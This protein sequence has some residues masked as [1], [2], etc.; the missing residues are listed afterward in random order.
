[1][2]KLKYKESDHSQFLPDGLQDVEP[3]D[4]ETSFTDNFNGADSDTPGV[5]LTWTELS[6]DWDV[7]SNEHVIGGGSGV[8]PP[9]MAR[10][11]SDVSSDDHYVQGV[12]V[13][14][15]DENTCSGDILVRAAPAGTYTGYYVTFNNPGSNVS[16][17][18]VT[19]GSTTGL[20]GTGSL[21][22]SDGDTLKVVIE[23]SDITAYQND[24]ELASWTDSTHT[25]YTR[26]GLGGYDRDWETSR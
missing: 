23:G 22:Y 21:S 17:S 19:D 14:I 15:G 8:N 24:V 12:S 3:I 13:E 4:P 16:A 25:G 7:S 10:A 6:G 5:Q 9:R 26:G 2:W 1:M 11:D 20:S 18:K